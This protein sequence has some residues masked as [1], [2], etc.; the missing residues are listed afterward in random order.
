M[1][2]RSISM[3]FA[4]TLLIGSAA[5]AQETVGE[6]LLKACDADLKQFCS[7]VTPGEGRL[8]HCVAAHEDK[9]SSQCQYALYQS[10][11]L[12]EELAV[13]IN[14]VAKECQTE[15]QSHCADVKMGEGRVLECLE[16]NDANVG[17]SCRQAIK[18]TVG[19]E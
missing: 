7:Q 15:I 8:L 4:A 19:E 16:K 2:I 9:I 17:A 14:Y 1:R 11:R 3:M 18:D 13:A 12:L 6:H 10:A 5:S